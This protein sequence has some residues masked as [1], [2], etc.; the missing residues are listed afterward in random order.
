MQN[1]VDRS[2]L[3]R[4]WANVNFKQFFEIIMYDN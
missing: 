3:I 1:Y 4:H 2:D